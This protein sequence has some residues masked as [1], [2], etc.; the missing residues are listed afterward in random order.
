MS[1][2]SG[3]EPG[4][5]SLL[6]VAT[7][8]QSIRNF[9]LPYAAHFRARGWQVDA[10][11]NGVTTD[12]PLQGVFDHLEELPLSRS[13]RDVR[14]L[15]RGALALRGILASDPDIVHVQTP[16][17]GFITRLAARS[18]PAER[19]PIVVYT[20]HGFHF[21]ETGHPLTNFAFLTAERTAGRWTDRLI[22]I[23]H[24]DWNAARQHR[25]VPA[26]RLL[27]MPGI[28]VDTEMYRRGAI[29]DDAVAAARA[30]I[31]V[32]LREPLFVLVSELN[33]NKRPEDAIAAL[34]LLRHTGA[35][36]VLVGPGAGH[37]RLDA[38]ARSLGVDRRVHFTGLVADVRPYV[39]GAAALLLAS[40]R[41]GLSRAIMEA[42]SLEVPVVASS[43][44]GNRQL[45]GADSGFIVATG[46]VQG[47][48]A[49]MDWLLENPDDARLMGQ[50]GRARMLE[51][52]DLQFL[53]HRHEE[54]YDELL[55]SGPA[56]R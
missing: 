41:E 49:H 42:L 12:P 6:Y 19:R 11:A 4:R 39:D 51:E 28:G 2:P 31:G 35:H 5:R 22:V 40:R 36:L 18:L 1:M 17:A 38:L 23:N 34:S 50:R 15:V 3:P 21:H 54:L 10:A 25:I 8:S 45:V 56:R 24:E 48:A 37:A 29:G 9:M 43:A 32:G 46:D 33:R 55:A 7:V 53:L 20:A 47:M 14:A 27:F 30:A 44:R 13:I 16:I 26:S 52:Y